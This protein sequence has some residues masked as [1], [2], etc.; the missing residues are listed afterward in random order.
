MVNLAGMNIEQLEIRRSSIF[1]ELEICFDRVDEIGKELTETVRE[2]ARQKKEQL[3][4][5]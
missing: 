5:S 2:I 1:R 4:E 3:N